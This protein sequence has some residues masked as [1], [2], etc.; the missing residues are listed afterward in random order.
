MSTVNSHSFEIRTCILHLRIDLWTDS[1]VNNDFAAQATPTNNKGASEETLSIF[2]HLICGDE[3]SATHSFSEGYIIGMIS[4]DINVSTGMAT[5]ISDLIRLANCN[6]PYL[7]ASLII[8]CEC[9]LNYLRLL[10]IALIQLLKCDSR[11]LFDFTP[12]GEGFNWQFMVNIQLW[13]FP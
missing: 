12:N 6:P 4:I 7:G 1:E 2:R 5:Q 13:C 9:Y 10:T 8:C 11:K 3:R